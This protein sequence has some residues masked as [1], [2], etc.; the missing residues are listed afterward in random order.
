MNQHLEEH[1]VGRGDHRV[2][3]AMM[4]SPWL[5][6]AL[7]VSLVTSPALFLTSLLLGGLGIALGIWSWSGRGRVALLAAGVGLVCGSVPYG[8]AALRVTVFG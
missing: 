1:D 4:R 5:W 8:L 2:L 6:G 7:I 3:A